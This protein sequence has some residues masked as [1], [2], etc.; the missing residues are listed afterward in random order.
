MMHAL[1]SAHFRISHCRP[2]QVFNVKN[3]KTQ[4]QYNTHM[5]ARTYIIKSFFIYFTY[6][7]NLDTHTDKLSYRLDILTCPDSGVMS[8]TPL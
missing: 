2:T 4:T 8:A 5:Y 7:D 6:E 1:H 3:C